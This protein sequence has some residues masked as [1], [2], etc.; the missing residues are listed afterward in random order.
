VSRALLV[1]GIALLLV[2][3]A[4]L[5]VAS[6]LLSRPPRLDDAVTRGQWI[7]LTGTDPDT[8]LPIPSSGGPLM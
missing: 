5:G 2:G 1:S 3:F 6:A 4:G 7:F 8:G